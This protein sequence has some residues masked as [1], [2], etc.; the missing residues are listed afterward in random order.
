MQG[1]DVAALTIKQRSLIYSVRFMETE[2]AA[3]PN[4]TAEEI[5]AMT[6]EE[7]PPGNMFDEE[8]ALMSTLYKHLRDWLRDR[9][10][11]FTAHAARRIPY[12]LANVVYKGDDLA[13]AHALSQEVVAR[14]R[15]GGG[16]TTRATGVA[17]AASPAADPV[18]AKTD[19]AAHNV[20]MRYKD[21][22][23][24][25]SGTPDQAWH[26]Y[27]AG[28]RQVMRD[29]DLP[30]ELQ[31]RLL[32]NLFGGE[33]KR[34]YDA[35]VDGAVATISEAFVKVSEEYNTPVRQTAVKNRLSALRVS[36][37]TALGQSE[38]QALESIRSTITRFAPQLPLT[39]RADEHKVDFLRHA[40]VGMRW[41]DNAVSRIPV[42]KPSFQRLF[43]QLDAALEQQEEGR[44]AVATDAPA[45]SAS[46]T[47]GASILYAGQGM[48]GVPNRGVGASVPRPRTGGATPTGATR[49][50]SSTGGAVGGHLRFDPLTVAGCF[51]CDN[52]SHTMRSCPL[53]R[54]ATKAAQRKLEY[55]AKKNAGARGGAAA[56]LFQMCQQYDARDPI[57]ESPSTGAADDNDT[58]YFETLLTSSL[59]GVDDFSGAD[60]GETAGQTDDLTRS[61]AGV[62][63]RGAGF[64][65][66]G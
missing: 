46:G 13:D 48:Y 49:T 34:Y 28:Y 61:T 66:G 39:H 43:L 52:P 63:E 14:S 20:A 64:G 18:P 50:G 55:F 8:V 42:D 10:L 36:Q 56:V 25:F 6:A 22:S 37:F 31:L 62:A 3:N 30:P 5:R 44:A 60:T 12:Q 1:N 24:K 9:G 35:H 54:N 27:M 65:M 29:Y 58:T 33:A 11:D 45:A 4:M 17:A 57:D 2:L 7:L 47:G 23:S 16:G 51:N 32:H 41:A 26:E 53:P 21:K 19:R 59:H 38:K 15:Q 40:V